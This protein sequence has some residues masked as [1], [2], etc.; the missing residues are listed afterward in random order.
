MWLSLWCSWYYYINYCSPHTHRNNCSRIPEH[1]AVYSGT[2]VENRLWACPRQIT[3]F[4]IVSLA[5]RRTG[6]A[7]RCFSVVYFTTRTK[8]FLEK[9]RIA[10][11][12]STAVPSN[13]N[14][15]KK[16]QK[17]K[18]SRRVFVFTEKTAR[19]VIPCRW[20]SCQRGVSCLR[21]QTSNAP[22]RRARPRSVYPEKRAVRS[23]P[24]ITVS[25]PAGPFSGTF[26]FVLF[27]VRWNICCSILRDFYFVSI[28]ILKMY[29][30]HTFRKYV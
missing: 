27:H 2:A 6:A 8:S 4:V 17:S 25:I 11:R 13:E 9:N 20:Q 19:T 7:R 12:S 5:I 1:F 22:Q 10:R 14:I 26:V 21:R 28:I 29:K 23:L 16:N 3:T 18:Y 30:N 15:E 24:K